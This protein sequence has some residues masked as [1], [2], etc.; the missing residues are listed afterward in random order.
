MD[1]VQHFLENIV[2]GE[3]NN[4]EDARQWYVKAI[5]YDYEPKV[6]NV[7]SDNAKKM[8]NINDQVRKSFIIPFPSLTFD[9]QSDTDEQLESEK[10]TEQEGQG[11]KILTPEQM[12]SR[13]PIS[14]AQLK[15]GNNS[16]K[17]K[18]K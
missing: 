4:R 12:L 9:E 17:P 7:N 1:P 6:R 14:L 5:F 16:E 13:L 15:A 3:Y 18:M 10:L 11:L 8:M 2:N